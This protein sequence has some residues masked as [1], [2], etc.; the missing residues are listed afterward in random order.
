MQDNITGRGFLRFLF[1]IAFAT[2]RHLPRTLYGEP[3]DRIFLYY[4]QNKSKKIGFCQ[5]VL[6]KNF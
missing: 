6:H 5:C 4:F 2:L 1:I 3:I